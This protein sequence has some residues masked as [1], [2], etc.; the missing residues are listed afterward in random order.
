MAFETKM[1]RINDIVLS[2][3]INIVLKKVEWSYIDA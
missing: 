3:Q 1:K 2:G